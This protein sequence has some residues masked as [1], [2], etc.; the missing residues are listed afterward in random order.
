MLA[1]GVAVFLVNFFYSLRNGRKA[2]PNPWG[3][4]ELEWATESPPINYGFLRL[5]IVRSRT[6]LW[7]QKNLTEGPERV[8]KLVEELA[9]WPTNWRAVLVTSALDGE[10]EEVFRVSGPSLWPFFT[11]VGLVMIF[12]AEIFSLRPVVLLGLLMLVAGIVGW[13]WPESSPTPTEEEEAFTQRHNIPVRPHGS[14]AVNRGAM[15][16]LIL[17]VGI[18]LTC[19]LFSYFFIRWQSPTWPPDNLP[20]PVLTWVGIGTLFMVLNGGA[21]RWTLGQVKAGKLGRLRLGLAIAFV[22][23]VAAAALLVYDLSQL[24]FDWRLNAYGSLFWI[25]NGFL[26][27]TLLT[28]MGMNL[29]IQGWSWRGIYDAERYEPVENTA[30]YW[31]ALIGVWVITV[32]V[33]Y[34][35]PYRF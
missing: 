26:L 34:L 10:P 5:P 3:A 7:S 11:A 35:L 32:G 15:W 17:L 18:A 13:N 30:V 19:L 1:A 20:L 21:L 28:G 14:R 27:L 23:E 4:S 33:L 12:G 8:K 24:P 6:P 9:R 31:T 25:I 29:F 2:A 22:L 16:L